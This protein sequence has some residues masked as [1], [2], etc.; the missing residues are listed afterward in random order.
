VVSGACG[1]EGL[2]STL[3]GWFDRWLEVVIRIKMNQWANPHARA[4]AVD[5]A[6]QRGEGNGLRHRA[7][8][9]LPARA[10]F[11]PPAPPPPVGQALWDRWC[12]AVLSA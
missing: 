7:G 3:E 12:E 11:E 6:L 5:I 8:M 1:L 2:R 9:T 10:W 4:A